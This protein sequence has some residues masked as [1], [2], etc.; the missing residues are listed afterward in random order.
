MTRSSSG[1]KLDRVAL[2]K[3]LNNIFLVQEESMYREATI[4]ATMGTSTSVVSAS[5]FVTAGL[6]LFS[7]S[8]PAL[9]ALRG[10]V[11]GALC[12]LH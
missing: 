3:D 6:C 9:D 10:W 5:F 4:S 12:A 11:L 8:F 2:E 7:S 1:G